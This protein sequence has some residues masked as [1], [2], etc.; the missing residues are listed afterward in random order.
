M[1][2]PF[3]PPHWTYQHFNQTTSTMDQA[4]AWLA[5]QDAFHPPHIIHADHQTQGY[6]Q[7][8]RSWVSGNGN[9][10]ASF[11]LPLNF[12]LKIIGQFSIAT[13]VALGRTL[14]QLGFQGLYHYKWPNDLFMNQ[15]KV[16]GILIEIHPNKTGNSLI[17]GMGLNI[18]TIPSFEGN[19]QGH[20]LK[21]SNPALNLTPLIFL[22]KFSFTYQETLRCW[23]EEGF[24]DIQ[25]SWVAHSQD[26][27]KPVSYLEKEVQQTGI[28]YGID[29]NGYAMVKAPEGQIVKFQNRTFR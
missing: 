3:L 13:I 23:K 27:N 10:Y 18:L 2:F 7:H 29:E 26:I 12:S 17:V 19:Y 8:G 24:C 20:S 25:D 21:K 9:L 6:G 22:E 5:Y 15:G 28:F 14:D 16:G 4:K 11:L 1:I